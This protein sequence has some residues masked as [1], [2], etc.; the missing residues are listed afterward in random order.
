MTGRRPL[1][2]VL[3]SGLVENP[4]GAGQIES[5]LGVAASTE[6]NLGDLAVWIFREMQAYAALAR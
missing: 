2:S 1:V 5:A 3:A 4:T 6:V